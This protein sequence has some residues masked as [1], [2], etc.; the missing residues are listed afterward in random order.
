MAEVA[1]RTGLAYTTVSYHRERLRQSA[2]DAQTVVLKPASG[3][4]IA[5]VTTREEV[6]RLLRAGCGRAEAARVLG[7]TKSTVTYHAKRFGMALDPGPARRYDWGAIQRYYDAGHSVRQCRA[8]FGFGSS[9]WASAVARGDVV[10]RPSAMPL[11]ELLA[12]PRGRAHLKGCLIK[13]GLLPTRCSECD[14]EDWRGQPLALELHHVNGDKKDNRLENLA[15]LC[16]NCHSQTDT[17]GGRNGARSLQLA[18]AS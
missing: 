13:A 4:L 18:S 6:R 12:A 17:W 1:R 5:P 14:I 3:G 7:I 8:T 11:A 16:P 9:T 10:A 15:L 2:D